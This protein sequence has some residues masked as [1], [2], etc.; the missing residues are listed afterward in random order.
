[1]I[2]IEDLAVKNLVHNGHLAKSIHDAAWS[3]FR[4]LI[5]CKAAWADRKYVAVNPAYTSQDCSGC[6]TRKT[7]LTL[8]DRV[9]HCRSCGLVMDRD[10]NAAQ[11][12]LRVGLHSLASA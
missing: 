9:Y 2:A 1:M 10:C 5:A 8:A 4:E 7:D 11:N 12:I 6:G 3:H